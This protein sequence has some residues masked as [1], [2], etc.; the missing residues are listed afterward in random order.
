MQGLEILVWLF[1]S[2]EEPRR[3][4][5]LAWTGYFVTATIN[6]NSFIFNHNALRPVRQDS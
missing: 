2:S 1:G 3:R 5:L 4:A 6:F